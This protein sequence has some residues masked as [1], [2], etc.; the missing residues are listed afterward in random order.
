ML[1]RGAAVGALTPIHRPEPIYGGA[2]TARYF[3]PHACHKALAITGAVGIATACVTPGTLA[4]DIAG[5]PA[6]PCTLAIEHPSSRLD[7][8]LEADDASAE[9]V[10]FVVRTARRLFEGGVH[11]RVPV[12]ATTETQW[13]KST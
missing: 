9:P 6:A 1:S 2:I 11:A 4:Y 12:R 7:V 8:R 5:A 10:A 3:M 13:L